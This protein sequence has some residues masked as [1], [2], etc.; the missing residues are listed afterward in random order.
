MIRLLAGLIAF[1]ILTTIIFEY[2][3]NRTS[4]TFYTLL[5]LTIESV[6]FYFLIYKP[7]KKLL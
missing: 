4:S 6:I 1:V 5:A 7:T 2:L 3:I